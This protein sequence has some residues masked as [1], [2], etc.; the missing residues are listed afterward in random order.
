MAAIPGTVKIEYQRFAEPIVP[1]SKLEKLKGIHTALWWYDLYPEHVSG[2]PSVATPEK[3]EEALKAIAVDIAQRI[4]AV[5]EDEETPK[6]Q[7]EFY[8]RMRKVG[9]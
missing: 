8:S 6:M 3:G 5:K 2:K 1:H 7:K 9:R 4:K